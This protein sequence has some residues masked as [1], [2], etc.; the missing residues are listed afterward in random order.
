M[1]ISFSSGTFNLALCDA[2]K[3]KP[4]IIGDGNV[5][6]SWFLTDES[7]LG[8]EPSWIAGI[9][10]LTVKLNCA[11]LWIIKSFNKLD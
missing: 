7:E 5:K 6:K 1:R 3:A 4:D 11:L 10:C 9:E 2:V 8:T